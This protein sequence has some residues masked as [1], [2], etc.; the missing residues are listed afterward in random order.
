[1]H[2]HRNDPADAQPA[3]PTTA[4][5]AAAGSP[6]PAAGE[7]DPVATTVGSS[8]ELVA[9]D[10]DGE[11][12]DLVDGHPITLTLDRGQV[13]GQA[14]CNTYASYPLDVPIAEDT[15]GGRILPGLWTSDRRCDEPAPSSP[16]MGLEAAYLEGLETITSIRVDGDELRL[17]GPT[18]ALTFIRT[19]TPATPSPSGPRTTAVRGLRTDRTW[20]LVEATVGGR[21]IDLA[22]DEARPVWLAT[23]PHRVDSTHH[24][25]ATPA[26][27]ERV[28]YVVAPDCN[29][30]EGTAVPG[31]DGSVSLETSSTTDVGCMGRDA[32][33]GQVV[34]AALARVTALERAE[35]ELL[36]TGED[37]ELRWV[38]ADLSQGARG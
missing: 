37:V 35:D 9:G 34:R 10:V 27:D 15:G 24:N 20:V 21:A 2:R 12:L 30:D 16:V 18:S 22:T 4:T 23:D 5:T 3:V 36:L 17:D 1:M 13:E 38:Q 29:H 33:R 19:T 7:T 25:L 28:P 14:G 32:T 26:T 6:S 11:A 8:W 31:A